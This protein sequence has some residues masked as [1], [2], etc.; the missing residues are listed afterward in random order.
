MNNE[1]R[2]LELRKIRNNLNDD[3]NYE[4]FLSNDDIV[5]LLEEYLNG[6]RNITSTELKRMEKISGFDYFIELYMEEN[7]IDIINNDV[8]SKDVFVSSHIKNYLSSLS[9]YPVLAKEEEEK[10]FKEYHDLSKSSEEREKV[11]DKIVKHNLR[12]VVSI[13][14]KYKFSDLDIM[15]VI[16]EGNEGLLK[17]ID[18][19]DVS[20]DN[21]FSTYATFWIKQS[22]RR[23][24]LETNSQIRIPT[25][26][27]EILRKLA[28][29]RSQYEDMYG[30]E[31]AINDSNI[32]IIADKL[33]TTESLLRSI[34]RITDNNIMSLDAPITDDSDDSFV[35]LLED[36]NI[37]VEDSAIGSKIRS[38]IVEILKRTLSEKE[39]DVI[40]R[41]N[42][43]DCIPETLEEI[44]ESYGIT[45][46]RVRQVEARALAKL[47]KNS[48]IIEIYE[49][50][51]NKNS[52]AK[53]EKVLE[54]K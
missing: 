18:K 14:K 20:K 35:D 13:A 5:R 44:G 10:L 47:K 23:N 32:D 49:A 30:E 31:L 17:A 36:E 28:K 21:K 52:N 15:D 24:A 48:K 40:V 1:E 43:I 34:L 41:R 33:E 22:I 45:R 42:G 53:K 25:H 39:L 9:R 19:F 6:R 16:E 2:L 29:L 3:F 50:M 27:H 51:Y 11:R 46:E 8:N 4:N 12:L 54:K 26:S 38:D 7:K 37:S